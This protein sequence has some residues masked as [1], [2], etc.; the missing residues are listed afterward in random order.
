MDGILMTPDE[1]REKLASVIEE[2]RTVSKL[3]SDGYMSVMFADSL[4]IADEVIK[5]VR[6]YLTIPHNHI[7]REIREPGACPGCDSYWY[8]QA[9]KEK[10]N[11]N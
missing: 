10:N 7:T 5:V 6:E 3:M 9:E 2:N 11:G 4:D 8:D 1:F